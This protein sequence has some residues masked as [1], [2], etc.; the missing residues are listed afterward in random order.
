MEVG[1]VGG[2]GGVS[3]DGSGGGGIGCGSIL[4]FT[5]L[6]KKTDVPIIKMME[7]MLRYVSL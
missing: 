6:N 3:T 5:L 1:E 4:L 2:G 7:P